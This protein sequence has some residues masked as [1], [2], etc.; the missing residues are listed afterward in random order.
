MVQSQESMM[1]YTEDERNELTKAVHALCEGELEFIS[2]P[3]H[4][5]LKVPCGAYV[6]SKFHA[7]PY[8]Y[9]QGD[10]VYLEEDLDAHGFLK[11]AGIVTRSAGGDW[12]IPERLLPVQQRIGETH[13]RD[14]TPLRDPKYVSP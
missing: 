3:A 13:P 12:Y 11:A 8:S 5:W 4:G 1:P 7:S 2:D 9:E 14:M 10:Y 6:L